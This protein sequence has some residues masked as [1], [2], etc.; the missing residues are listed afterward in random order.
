MNVLSLFD[1]ISCGQ[2]ALQRAGIPVENYYASEID[3]KAIKVTQTNF[4]ATKQIGSVTG[5]DGAKYPDVKLLIG[6]SPCQGFSF[7][8]AQAAFDDPRSKLVLDYARIKGELP[9]IKWCLLENV[10]MRASSQ[11]VISKLM[12]CEPRLIDSTLVSA[13]RRK[14]L[15]W[16]NIPI[17]IGGPTDKGIVFSDVMLPNRRGSWERQIE[18]SMLRALEDGKCIDI[19]MDG[20]SRTVTTKQ[21]RWNNAG[22]VVDE[23][24]RRYL[25]PQECERL[26]T[27]PVDYTKALS[28]PQRYA[29]IGNAWTVDVIAWILSFIPKEDWV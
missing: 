26:Q 19:P 13:Q 16:T 10:P 29:V 5:V 21:R 14:R 15:Y 8:G 4:P 28:D 3:E 25:T 2:L 7:V 27:I 23:L 22:F 6:G 17:P 11:N 12:G 20:K 9:N 18:L 1:G 24:G